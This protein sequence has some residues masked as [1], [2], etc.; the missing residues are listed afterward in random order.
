MR[1]KGLIEDIRFGLHALRSWYVV[2]IMN[3][4]VND[5]DTQLDNFARGE[6]PTDPVFVDDIVLSWCYRRSAVEAVAPDTGRFAV[7]FD[8][9]GC[10]IGKARIDIFII[11]V[12]SIAQPGRL[13]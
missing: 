1:L 9:L 8:N 6:T 3:I 13:T 10:P 2:D 12:G 7:R 11:R 4:G 5:R